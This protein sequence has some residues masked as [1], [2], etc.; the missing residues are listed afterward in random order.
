MSLIR[1]SSTGLWLCTS[2]RITVPVYEKED[3]IIDLLSSF[4]FFGRPA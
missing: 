4:F 3:A 1:Y 2:G